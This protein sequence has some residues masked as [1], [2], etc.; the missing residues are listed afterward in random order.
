MRGIDPPLSLPSNFFVCEA[1]I[2]YDRIRHTDDLRRSPWS[3]PRNTGASKKRLKFGS[4]IA[5]GKQPV[6]H[7]GNESSILSRSTNFMVPLFEG[8]QKTDCESVH[9][10]SNPARYPKFK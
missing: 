4:V 5:N 8:L 3:G 10:G 7:A 6:L 2:D 1:S 9:A